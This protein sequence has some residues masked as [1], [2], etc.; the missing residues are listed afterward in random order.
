MENSSDTLSTLSRLKWNLEM[1]VFEEGGKL[2]YLEKKPLRACKDENQQ[3]TQTQT[4]TESG[5]QTRPHWWE[6]SALTTV[7]SLLPLNNTLVSI[8]KK[9]FTNT[10][11]KMS[12]L[13]LCLLCYFRIQHSCWHLCIFYF[14][15]RL[16]L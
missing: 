12:Y 1:L 9:I 13:Q 15:L 3:Q 4:S 10:S 8:S 6:V 2:E 7:P 16:T 14:R 11:N 5:N